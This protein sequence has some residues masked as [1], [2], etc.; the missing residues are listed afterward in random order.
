MKF[1]F[2]ILQ[3]I[4]LSALAGAA[5]VAHRPDTAPSRP[6]GRV[7][8]MA[9]Q[10]RQAAI[11]RSARLE[12]SEE[13]V[14]A[15]LN[16]RLA[17]AMDPK[18]GEWSRFDGLAVDLSEGKARLVTR[19]SLLG[20]PRTVSVD[21]GIQREG[22]VFEVRVLGGAYGRLKV[23][24]GL[25]RPMAPF[26]RRLSDVFQPELEQLFKMNQITIDEGKLVLDPRF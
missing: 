15:S 19:W 26:L 18:L 11:K 2:H 12:W 6:D 17:A 13:A 4:L 23:F 22:D 9:D 16:A 1:L 21:L 5:W 7:I 14:D 8:D 20:Q 3:L 25:L 24:R 10:L